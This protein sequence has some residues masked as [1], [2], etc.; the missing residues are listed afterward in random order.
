[1]KYYQTTT[2]EYVQGEPVSLAVLRCPDG[3]KSAKFVGYAPN[4]KAALRMA[5]DIPGKTAQAQIMSTG[6]FTIKLEPD[7]D[8]YRDFIEVTYV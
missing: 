7:G 2:G 5:G 4:E 8:L 3:W 6:G 1:M